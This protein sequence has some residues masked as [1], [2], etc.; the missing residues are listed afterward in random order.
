MA[1]L[2][3]E[4]LTLLVM[5]KR[6]AP[7]GSIE[8]TIAELLTQQNPILDDIVWK[9]SNQVTGHT[10][11]IRTGLP[12]VY[13][14]KI[15]Q[16]VPT[17][18]STTVQVT[19]SMGMLEGRS[20]ID[21]KLADLNGNTAAFRMS[22]TKPFIESMN[23]TFCQTLLYGDH[24]VDPEQFLGLAPRYATISGATNGQNILDAGGTGGDNTSMWLVGHGADGMF[25]IFPK[26]TKAGLSHLE[27]KDGSSDGC[28]VLTDSDGNTFRGYSD[29]FNWD[30]GI[31]VKDWRNV[32]R[33]ANIDISE[34]IAQA[35]S[36]AATASTALIKMMSRAIDRLPAQ[37]ANVKPV[38]YAHRT[39]FS[40]LRVAALD[41]SAANLG[42]F[43][44][45]NQFGKS[46]KELQFDGIPVRLMDQQ[47]I[48]ETRIT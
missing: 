29:R 3:S 5:T 40:M 41:K 4:Y 26:G 28:T 20:Q 44:A 47:L 45:M 30:G 24:T 32:V 43:D 38:F 8:N 22:E 46:R 21:K 6:M 2:N 16:G 34:L 17:G 33:I 15:N 36:Q 11:T 10:V 9:E 14:R 27:E 25:G 35:T 12:A 23:Q 7:D 31:V 48:A 42:I 18:K 1:T 19:E 37:G 13:Y 39:V